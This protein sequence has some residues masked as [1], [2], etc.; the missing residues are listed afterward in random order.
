MRKPALGVE[1]ESGARRGCDSTIDEVNR[2]GEDAR[3]VRIGE[4][5]APRRAVRPCADRAY[6]ADIDQRRRQSRPAQP[7][8]DAVRGISLRDA[9]QRNGCAAWSQG[10]T[11]AQRKYVMTLDPSRLPPHFLTPPDQGGLD[12]GSGEIEQIKQRAL[13]RAEQ[14]SNIYLD[15]ADS[16]DDQSR[17]ELAQKLAAQSIMRLAGLRNIASA[18]ALS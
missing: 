17:M 16:A 11:A 12:P 2:F 9:V 10:L 8:D 7:L 6:L 1:P 5:Y 13:R 18:S 4:A 14:L 3:P 15:E